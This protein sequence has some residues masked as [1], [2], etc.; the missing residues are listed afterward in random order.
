MFAVLM[1]FF[2]SAR[3]EDARRNLAETGQM[4][5]DSLAPALE[6]AVVSGN[7]TALEQ[8][9]S[10]SL[11][12]SDADWI[13][14]TD[15]VGEQMGFVEKTSHPKPPDHQTFLIYS[16]EILQEP[17][18][19]GPDDGADWI[20]SGWN[21]SSGSLRVG[22]VEV[23]MDPRVLEARQQ[24][25]LWSSLLV[26]AGVL[27]LTILL[28]NF[29]LGNILDP[30]RQLGTRVTRLIEGKYDQ[31]PLPPG[32]KTLEV[33]TLQQQLNELAEH[34]DQLRT[35]RDQTLAMSEH[36]RERAEHASQ[37]KSEFL[38]TMSH[39]LR[40][41]L[42]GVLGMVELVQEEPLTS[43]QM[44]YLN[45]ARQST[46][47][48]LTVISDILDYARMDN[49][50][51]ELD[52][53]EFNLRSL[54]SNCCASY[55]HAAEKQGLTLDNQ[56]L[57]EWPA[58]PVVVGDAPRVRQI[59]AGLLDNALKFTSD[60]FVGIKATWIE[61]EHG[62]M[63]L[64]CSVSDSGAGIAA[65]RLQSVFNTFEQAENGNDRSFGGMGMG[66]ALVQRLAELMGGHIQV[67]S[68]LGQGS[69]FR[70]ELPFELAY[71]PETP[72]PAPEQLAGNA[73]ALVVEDNRVNQKVT[74]ALLQKLGFEVDSAN[75]G[76]EAMRS[77][78]QNHRGYD[79]I[80]MDCQMPLMDGYE[81]T[82]RIRE[83]EHSN[84]QSGVPI[85]A[86]TADVS[87]ETEQLCRD[88]GMNDYL[89]KPVRRDT[90]RHVLSRWI[91]I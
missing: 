44:D 16:A 76:E 4:L 37:A 30:V 36:A 3:L 10:V 67:E 8:V 72:L 83:W 11:R 58:L 84:G 73:R 18:D 20:S 59:L 71:Q 22:T 65:D 5:A 25:I 23:G 13:R 87:P 34:L 77:L 2:T 47:D 45:T 75:N 61:L 19:L 82:R 39:E 63:V 6:Y 81:A 68:D 12:R 21:F 57:G 86:L 49:G 51:L 7:Q 70:F 31:Q 88:T 42:N 62:C 52:H 46:E 17:L 41:P 9:L 32:V 24:D 66:L 54:I 69:S 85:I 64:N 40:T 14:V 26:G 90:L 35:A 74:R 48:L 55:R 15:V 38:A 60:G 43:R 80:L 53:H 56:F 33:S 1:I 89:T 78:K 50:A 79:V 29:F 28:V 27:F 91:R